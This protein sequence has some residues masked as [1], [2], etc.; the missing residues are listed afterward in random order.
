M[1]ILICLRHDT[2]QNEVYIKDTYNEAEN[3]AAAFSQHMEDV[4][5]IIEPKKIHRVEFILMH[6]V[7]NITDLKNALEA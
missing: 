2:G 5:W 6:E 3:Y 7:K 1:V 4:W